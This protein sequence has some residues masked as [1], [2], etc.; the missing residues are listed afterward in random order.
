MRLPLAALFLLASSASVASGCPGKSEPQA[1]EDPYRSVELHVWTQSK[2]S[3]ELYWLTQFDPKTGCFTQHHTDPNDGITYDL[4]DCSLPELVRLRVAEFVGVFEVDPEPIAVG[5]HVDTSTAESGHAVVFERSEGT[6]W[7]SAS[8]LLRSGA[9]LLD[10]ELAEL[11]LLGATA[12]GV[13][14][15]PAGW[16]V[17]TL[18]DENDLYERQLHADGHWSCRSWLVDEASLEEFTFTRRGQLDPS[19]AA[20]MIDGFADGLVSASLDDSSRWGTALTPAQGDV[21]AARSDALVGLWDAF[22][23]KL[24]PSCRLDP[25]PTPGEL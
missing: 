21:L 16:V 7:T 17:L 12:V 11:L 10:G 5:E 18:R 23:V 2:T 20:A 9:E 1:P 14:P 22:A 8:K 6:R 25:L 19:E 4:R 3:G 15:T 24:D 13:E